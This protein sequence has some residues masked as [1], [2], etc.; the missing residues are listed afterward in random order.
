[1]NKLLL[2]SASALALFSAS[3]VQ[4]EEVKVDEAWSAIDVNMYGEV[5]AFVEGGSADG[6]DLE[7]KASDTKIGVKAKSKG[8][9]Y[10][11]GNLMIAV[12]VN[13]DGNDD[14]RT[15]YGYVGIGAEKL[16]ELSGGR[17]KSLADD[18]SNKTDVF[19]SA[20]NQAVQKPTKQMNSSLKYTNSLGPIAIGAQ[21]QLLDG[22][23]DET[24]DLYQVGVGYNGVVDAG[25]TMANDVVNDITYFGAG[26]SKDIG[27]IMVAAG[28]SMTQPDAGTDVLGMEAV[29]GY[30]LGKA[31]IL[32]GF[33]KTDAD[34]DDGDVTGELNYK[35]AKWATG[36][37]NVEYDVASSDYVYRAG[38]SL[39]W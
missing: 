2:A 39:T 36:F 3:V 18:M 14:L 10:A 27:P 24:V 11:F 4:A 25:L 17:T 32:G 31:Q 21:A 12:D 38:L 9:A 8:P 34:A 28:V 22:T 1:M 30:T 16:G 7:V 19:M 15:L 37:T 26:V 6:K 35:F 33:A 23:T 5:R 20:G 13:A 29:A